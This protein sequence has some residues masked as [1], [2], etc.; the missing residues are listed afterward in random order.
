[1]ENTKKKLGALSRKL[2]SN[3]STNN[4]VSTKYGSRRP[5]LVSQKCF[6]QN[7]PPLSQQASAIGLRLYLFLE[8]SSWVLPPMAG[9][10]ARRPAAG[11]GPLRPTAGIE[12]LERGM[13]TSERSK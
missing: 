4:G 5:L 7:L 1:M 6:G 9:M 8:V 11:N 3:T 2:R 13:R 12:L 10:G